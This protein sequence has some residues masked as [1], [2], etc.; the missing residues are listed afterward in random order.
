M[1]E[2]KTVFIV[3]FSKNRIDDVCDSSIH[4]V[5]DCEKT[6]KEV[7]RYENEYEFNEYH[8]FYEEYQVQ[9]KMK[10]TITQERST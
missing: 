4:G 6:A 8:Y 1:S 10:Q 7:C 3:Q 5:Y 2:S 9:P